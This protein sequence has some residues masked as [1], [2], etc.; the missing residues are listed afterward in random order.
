MVGISMESPYKTA[1]QNM[2]SGQ[3]IPNRINDPRI[4][5]A[6]GSVPR[7]LFLPE[8]IRSRAYA[9]ET[10]YA[11]SHMLMLSPRIQAALFLAADLKE[12]DFV[13]NVKSGLGYSAAVMAGISQ[14]VVALEGDSSLCEA[15]QQIL[16][17]SEIDNVAVLNQNPDEGFSS[18][19]PFDVIFIE[20]IITHVPE[21]LFLQLAENGRLICIVSQDFEDVAHV[22]K[23]VKSK[24]SLTHEVLFD[25]DL[26]GFPRNRLYKRFVFDTVS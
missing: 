9:D 7:E 3:L 2:L 1:R 12:S 6:M 19:A 15:A 13:L 26:T 21:N 25:L 10:I 5:N 22:T 11:D 14:A 17:D 8:R 18:Q 24:N 23:T 4:L 20:G 16:I